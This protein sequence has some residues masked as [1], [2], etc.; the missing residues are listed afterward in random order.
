MKFYF[1]SFSDFFYL[2]LCLGA[3]TTTLEATCKFKCND[4]LV[5][6]LGYIETN[7]PLCL[8]LCLCI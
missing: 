6:F 4:M 2:F 1:Y 7:G 3:T 8:C 5:M